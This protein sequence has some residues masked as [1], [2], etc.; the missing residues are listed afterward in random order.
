M[1]DSMLGVSGTQATALYGGWMKPRS[2]KASV[3]GVTHRGRRKRPLEGSLHP[4]DI[5]F[6]AWLH[7]I[8]G[9]QI[10]TDN[11]L[12]KDEMQNFTTLIVNMAKQE[13]LLA[14]QGGPIILTQISRI[15][16]FR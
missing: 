13:N 2:T 3:E 12:Y 14:H 16:L 11:Q 10:R 6:P 4:I 8:P 7:Q 9:L 1:C 15:T 5:G